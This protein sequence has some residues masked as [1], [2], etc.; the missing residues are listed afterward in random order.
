MFIFQA[1]KPVSNARQINLGERR[2]KTKKENKDA[3]VEELLGS[4]GASSNLA[5][6][7]VKSNDS[8]GNINED[9]WGGDFDVIPNVSLQVSVIKI[10]ISTFLL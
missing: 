9:E 4:S 10:K 2:N 1:N 7:Q 8:W 5:A 3:L 6:D